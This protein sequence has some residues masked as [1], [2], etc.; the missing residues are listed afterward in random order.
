MHPC[1][2]F[3][4]RNDLFYKW[5]V[6]S[7]SWLSCLLEFSVFISHVHCCFCS[8]PWKQPLW[9]SMW[10]VDQARCAGF[11]RSWLD[12]EELRD[13]VWF[14]LKCS[15]DSPGCGR[16][17]LLLPQLELWLQTCPLLTS[18]GTSVVFCVVRAGVHIISARF[19]DHDFFSFLLG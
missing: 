11:L 7:G 3:D 17:S 14:P 4:L 6:Q 5:T 13:P 18:S 9:P 1:S 15:G 12:P 16:V 19:L 10:S 2:R 8:C